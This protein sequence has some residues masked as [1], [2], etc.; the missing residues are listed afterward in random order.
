MAG[1]NT[2]RLIDIEV[3]VMNGLVFVQQGEAEIVYTWQ[4]VDAFASEFTT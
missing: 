3:N 1:F 2:S 4:A